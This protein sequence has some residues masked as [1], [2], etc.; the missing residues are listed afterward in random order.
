MKNVLHKK[1]GLSQKNNFSGELKFFKSLFVLPLI[2]FFFI[3]VSFAQSKKI[4]GTITDDKGVPLS[5]V[6]VKIKGS[7]IGA[8]TDSVGLFSI[9][10][11]NEKAVLVVSYIGY[12]EQEVTVGNKNSLDVRLVPASSQLTDVVVV[13]Y[14]TQ[15]KVTVTGAVAQVKGSELENSPTVNLSN[16]LAGRLPGITAVQSSGEPGYDGSTIRIR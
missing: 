3:S 13:G 15:R 1:N 2:L 8:T 12:Q 7:S 5:N 6:S 16:A 14:G 10:V 11:P 4:S 9:N